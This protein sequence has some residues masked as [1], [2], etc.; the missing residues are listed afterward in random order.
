MLKFQTSGVVSD[1]KRSKARIFQQFSK[2]LFIWLLPKKKS[3]Q[4][5]FSKYFFFFFLKN[6]VS[7]KNVG[8]PKKLENLIPIRFLLKIHKCFVFISKRKLEASLG[9]GKILLSFSLHDLTFNIGATQAFETFNLFSFLSYTLIKF[10]ELSQNFIQS[11]SQYTQGQDN[12][13]ISF[14]THQICSVLNISF[15]LTVGHIYE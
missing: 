2:K 10:F 9:K 15:I 4:L 3:L 7:I 12:I 5:K 14:S 13:E 11:S 1:G 6:K 8:C